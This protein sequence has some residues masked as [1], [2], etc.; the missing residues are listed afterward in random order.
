MGAN[1]GRK[2]HFVDPWNGSKPECGL[3]L[4]RS[5]YAVRELAMFAKLARDGCACKNCIRKLDIYCRTE[6]SF[7]RRWLDAKE[8]ALSAS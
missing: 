7:T 4:K 2:F 3:R 1:G 5:A 8:R 6:D